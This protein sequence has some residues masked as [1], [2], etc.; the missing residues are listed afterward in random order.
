[1]A[2]MKVSGTKAKQVWTIAKQSPAKGIQRPMT[3][4]ALLEA[5][6]SGDTVQEENELMTEFEDPLFKDDEEES[7][8]TNNKASV[9]WW[10]AGKVEDSMDSRL[11]ILVHVFLNMDPLR[12]FSFFG[13]AEDEEECGEEEEESHVDEKSESDEDE[14]WRSIK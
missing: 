8:V 12:F 11:S 6:T 4:V 14:T 13:D 1:M 7:S 9:D 5:N 3:Q 2:G 10:F